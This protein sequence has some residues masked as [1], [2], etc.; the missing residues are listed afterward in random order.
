MKKIYIR[1]LQVKRKQPQP[2]PDKEEYG[3]FL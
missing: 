2:Y 3:A 1:N